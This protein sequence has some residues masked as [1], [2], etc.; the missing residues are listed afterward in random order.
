LTKTPERYGLSLAIGGAEVT[1]MELAAGYATLGRQGRYIPPSMTID[2]TDSPLSSSVRPRALQG[3]AL[4]DDL[5]QLLRQKQL[6]AQSCLS[7]LYSLGDR[8]RTRSVYPPAVALGPAWKTGT[9][10]GHRD[11]WC[12]GVTPQRTVVV[13]LGNADGSGSDALVGQSAAAPLALRVL[14]LADSSQNGNGFA[15]PP[16]F[17]TTPEHP[18]RLVDRAGG[19]IVVL[20][21]TNGQK[22]IRDTALPPDRQRIPLRGRTSGNSNTLWWFVDGKCIGQSDATQPCWWNPQ[23][24][25][26]EFRATD[27]T[28]HSASISIVVE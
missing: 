7:A 24:G 10:S 2:A 11:A 20:S 17:K 4:A 19:G 1:P 27:Q 28:G 6:R 15:P 14:T 13:W 12:A 21:P 25:S 5:H 16:D 23:Q 8:E 26:H 22:I 3:A 9:S 18:D